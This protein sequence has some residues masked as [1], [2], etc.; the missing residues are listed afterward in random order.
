MNRD[1]IMQCIKEAFIALFWVIIFL[2]IF[3]PSALDTWL[4]EG[5]IN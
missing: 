3:I 5:F 2:S 1:D 4:A